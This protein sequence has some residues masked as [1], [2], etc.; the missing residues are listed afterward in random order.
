MQPVTRNDRKAAI[1]MYIARG[2]SERT[3]MTLAIIK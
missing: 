2:K 1:R 3:N